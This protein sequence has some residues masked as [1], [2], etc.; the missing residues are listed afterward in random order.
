V[1]SERPIYIETKTLSGIPLVL[2]EM[3]FSDISGISD[4]I[5]APGFTY[6]YLTGTKNPQKN[7]VRPL[8]RAAEYVLLAIATRIFA[9]FLFGARRHW[10]IGIEN[11]VSRGLIGV[12]FLVGVGRNEI[13]KSP[14]LGQYFLE[15][16]KEHEAESLGLGELGFFVHPNH[17]RKGIATQAS[18]VLVD[19][20]AN[21]ESNIERG[22]QILK[23]IWAQTPETNIPSRN[24]LTKIKLHHSPE[25]TICSSQSSRYTPFGKPLTMVHFIQPLSHKKGP[26]TPIRNWLREL[27]ESNTV[28]AH[29][30]WLKR[31]NLSIDKK[32]N[33]N[34]SLLK[35]K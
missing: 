16:H 31:E 7:P 34:L 26:D 33:L 30:A 28:Y 21:M 27:K 29:W 18:Y 14:K 35:I 24:L 17:W 25:K 12:V 22:S 9:R 15:I 3:Q 19:A 13:S 32:N 11:R 8:K 4:C 5:T 20:L 1:I 6:P 23:E 10:V 2:R